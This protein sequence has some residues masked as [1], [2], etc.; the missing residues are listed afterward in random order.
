M[1]EFAS[2]AIP[3]IE[4]DGFTRTL[5]V[6]FRSSMT[7]YSY[8]GVPPIV[9]RRFCEATSKGAF[10]QRHVRPRYDLVAKW[11]ELDQTAA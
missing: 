3:R 10:F 8:E 6:W 4:Y 1:P 9:Y 7:R 5:H 11:D 2:A